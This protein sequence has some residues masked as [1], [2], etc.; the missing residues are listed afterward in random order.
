M[1]RARY[2][3]TP[4]GKIGHRERYYRDGETAVLMRWSPS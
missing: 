3:D 1:E 4:V 2:T